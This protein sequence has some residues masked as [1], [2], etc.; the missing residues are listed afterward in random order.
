MNILTTRSAVCWLRF[1]P[2]AHCGTTTFSGL[3]AALD[4][5]VWAPEQFLYLRQTVT[6]PIATSLKRGRPIGEALLLLP[7]QKQ[8]DEGESNLQGDSLRQKRHQKEHMSKC[9]R[10]AL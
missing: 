9:E 2:A 10:Q 6:W 1:R 7:Y 4:L 3:S 5:R 8:P